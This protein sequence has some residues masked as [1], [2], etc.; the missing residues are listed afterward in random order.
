MK[1]KA[2]IRHQSGT[3]VVRVGSF[4]NLNYCRSAIGHPSSL[5]LRKKAESAEKKR[6]LTVTTDLDLGEKDRKT[7]KKK[8]STV[9][10]TSQQLEEQVNFQS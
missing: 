2:P 6:F 7:V 10:P 1:S 5:H 3:I 8:Q 9:N 4:C